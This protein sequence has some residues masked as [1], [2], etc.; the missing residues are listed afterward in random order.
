MRG[1]RGLTGIDVCA[2]GVVVEVARDWRG[3]LRGEQGHLVEGDGQP[4][5]VQDARDLCHGDT[6]GEPEPPVSVLASAMCHN[7]CPQP[8]P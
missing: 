1:E 6:L 2:E 3:V 7:P 8:H 5:R 4:Q